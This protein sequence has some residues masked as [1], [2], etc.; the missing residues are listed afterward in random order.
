MLALIARVKALLLTPGPA[1]EAI[2]REAADPRRLTLR[3]VAPLAAIPA[4]AII[5]ALYVIGVQA[6]G[7]WHRAPIVSVLFSAFVF[8]GLTVTAVFAF[9]HIINWLA[10]RFGAERSYRQAFKVSAYSITAA[11]VA[12][13]LAAWPALQVFALLGASYSLYLL[14]L[15]V[16]RLMHP[17]PKSAVNYSI[18]VIFAAIGVAL[19]V[20][21]SAML[22]AGPTGNPFPQ[23][24]RLQ[25]LERSDTPVLRGADAAPPDLSGVLRPGGGGQVSNGD[26]RGAAPAQLAGLERVAAGVERTGQPGQRTVRLEAEYR[27]G[28]TSLSLQI[29]YSPSIAQVIGFGG[30]STSEFDRETADGYSRRRRVGDAIIVEDW[31]EASQ[32]GSYGRLVDDSFY[33]RATGRS[34]SPADLRAAVEVF[35]EETL[36]QFAAGS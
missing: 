32:S 35:G 34:V 12:G 15:G 25:L 23:F 24:P 2:D 22:V 33:V 5:I 16:P 20:G 27:G 9:A 18:V 21:M 1:W 26:L 8:F 28:A 10:P 30:V 29:V 14:F 17:P 36:A 11:M 3:Y 6:G 19:V 31:N 13:V 7:D 4:I